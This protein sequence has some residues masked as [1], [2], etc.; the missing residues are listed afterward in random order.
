MSL[1]EEGFAAGSGETRSGAEAA[2]GTGPP[3]E[4]G[5][6]VDRS[7][8]LSRFLSAAPHVT[9]K[10]YPGGLGVLHEV[11]MDASGAGVVGRWPADS[12]SIGSATS[13]VKLTMWTSS[14]CVGVG[15]SRCARSGE[16][17][18]RSAGAL[19]IPLGGVGDTTRGGRSRRPQS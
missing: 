4:R 3:I 8:A 15:S 7:G 13:S 18:G 6:S 14:S 1:G 9:Q 17:C 19:E 5:L 2:G 12:G 11:Q 10:R 16:G